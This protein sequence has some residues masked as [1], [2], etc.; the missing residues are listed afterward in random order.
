MKLPSLQPD[1]DVKSE[2]LINAEWKVKIDDLQMWIGRFKYARQF[3]ESVLLLLEELIL[4]YKNLINDC[5]TMRTLETMQGRMGII[6]GDK[7]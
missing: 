6:K 3:P 2:H 5:E 7:K 4:K 1:N